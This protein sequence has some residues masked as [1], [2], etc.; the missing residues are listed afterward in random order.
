MTAITGGAGSVT[1]ASGYA[2]NVQSWALSFVGTAHEITDFTAATTGYKTFLPGLKEWSG[3]YTCFLDDTTKTVAPS[4]A[5]A[6]A[7]F[8]ID[9][10]RKLTGNIIV[11][12]VSYDT[13][14]DGLVM[15]TVSFRGTSTLTID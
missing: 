7:I 11:E 6:E 3:S 15:V 10:T 12:D 4:G 2:V 5:A 14:A 13:P 1:F 8:S 9:G